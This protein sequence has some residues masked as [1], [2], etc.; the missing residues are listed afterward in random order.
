MLSIGS[1]T[2][3]LSEDLVLCVCRDGMHV[4]AHVL[5]AVLGEAAEVLLRKGCVQGGLA[6][7]MPR[8]CKNTAD[9]LRAAPRHSFPKS[10]EPEVLSTL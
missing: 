5:C 9:S 1:H 10:M 6:E 8:N 2:P 3:E 7:E 4:Q